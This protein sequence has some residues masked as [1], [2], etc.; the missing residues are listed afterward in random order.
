MAGDAGT[1]KTAFALRMAIK[2]AEKGIKTLF[3][4]LEMSEEALVERYIYTRCDA[5]DEQIE[6]Q[7]FTQTQE[8]MI[9]RSLLELENDKLS[10]IDQTT[11]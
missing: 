4:S 9:D 8:S 11:V 10:I 2:N 5:S 6:R 1:G 7:E 3:V